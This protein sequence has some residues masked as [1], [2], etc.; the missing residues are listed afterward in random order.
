MLHGPVLEINSKL[1]GEVVAF[2]DQT[3]KGIYYEERP[4]VTDAKYCRIVPGMSWQNSTG[5]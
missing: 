2:K 4:G 1:K 3:A 5:R